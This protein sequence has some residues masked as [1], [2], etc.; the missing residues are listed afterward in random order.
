MY[1]FREVINRFYFEKRAKFYSLIFLSAL[2]AFFEF[3]GLILIFQFVLF[4]TNPSSKICKK[5]LNFFVDNLNIAD[6]AKISLILGITIAFVY[7]LK[8]IYDR[9]T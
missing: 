1:L 3:M 6:F 7:I 4:L 8:N 2:A 5:V 9:T